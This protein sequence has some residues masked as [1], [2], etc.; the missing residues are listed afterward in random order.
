MGEF[1]K[2]VHTPHAFFD[3]IS[4]SF[5]VKNVKEISFINDIKENFEAEK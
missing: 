3:C 5:C 4:C 1:Y 2:L